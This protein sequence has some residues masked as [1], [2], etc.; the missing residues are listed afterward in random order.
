MLTTMKLPTQSGHEERLRIGRAHG[1]RV[2]GELLK[3]R[4]LRNTYRVIAMA[5]VET[6]DVPHSLALDNQHAND[7][8]GR[9][10]D[11]DVVPLLQQARLPQHV[12][13]VD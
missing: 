5:S 11:P 8:S 6:D 2:T 1:N 7:A 13:C 10:I 4:K 12:H 9:S 3:Q